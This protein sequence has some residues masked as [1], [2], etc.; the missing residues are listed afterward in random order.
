M[1]QQSMADPR[2]PDEPN[3]KALT[4][5]VKDGEDTVFEAGLRSRLVGPLNIYVRGEVVFS[6]APGEVVDA[7]T[8][9]MSQ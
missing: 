1:K 7:E 2:Y 9:G 5:L 3:R 4:V 6:V 8:L